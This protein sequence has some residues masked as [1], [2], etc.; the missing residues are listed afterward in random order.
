MF[1]EYGKP[2]QTTALPESTEIIN[3]FSILRAKHPELAKISTHIKNEGRRDYR[4]AQFDKLCGMNKGFSD[5]LILGDP[6]F[7]CELKT[8]KKGSALSA[9]QKQF[10]EDAGTAGAFACVAYGSA[11]ALRAVEDWLLCTKMMKSGCII[12]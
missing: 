7:V 10:L 5:I 9:H 4:Q 3:F 11:N 8:L 12:S 2:S 6:P 1:K